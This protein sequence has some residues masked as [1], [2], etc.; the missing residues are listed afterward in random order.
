MKKSL[1]ALATG[2]LLVGITPPL[3]AQQVVD[4]SPAN[5]SIDSSPT[6]SIS[7]QFDTTGT[8]PIDLASVKIF[9]NDRDVTADSTITSR[10]FTYRPPQAFRAG[11]PVR[12]RVEYRSQNG[13]ARSTAWTYTVQPAQSALSITSV[14]HNGTAS[15]NTDERLII[16]I[17][18]TR[19]AEASVLLIQD[20]RTV[21]TL[22][23]RETTPGVYVSR[24]TIEASDRIS[25]GVIVARLT[26]SGRSVYAAASQPIQVNIASTRPVPTPTPPI[27]PAPTTLQPRFTSHREGDQ[28]GDGS[29]TLVGETL[30]NATVEVSIAYGV[31]ALGIQLGETTLTNRTVTADRNGRFEVEVTAPPLSIPGLRYR[32]QA[33]AKEGNRT[34]PTTQITLRQ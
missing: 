7:G 28:V 14:T 25:E 21:Q 2:L 23:A 20:G 30:P 9:V 3:S 12:V 17:N 4:L 32:V 26:A 1:L 29:F 18:G 8:G 34:S 5:N 33:I 27:S 11:E 24:S 31:S 10:F 13:P 22:P 6:A 15:L 16:T 19:G